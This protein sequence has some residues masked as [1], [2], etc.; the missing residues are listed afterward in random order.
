MS[1]V[2]HL[3][4]QPSDVSGVVGLMSTDAAA[5]DP[6]LDVNG[7]RFAGIT[8][9][10][11]PFTA[12]HRAPVGDLWLGFRYVPPNA[13]GHSISQSTAGFLEFFDAAGALLAKVR[14]LDSD[15]RYHAEAHGDVIVQGASSYVAPTGQPHWIDV[16]LAV[17]AEITIEFY[18]DGVLQSAA[19]APNGGGKGRPVLTV[20]AN[21]GLHNSLW[22][23][24]WYYAHVAILDGVPTIGRRFVRRMPDAV[25]TYA[26]MV[27]SLDALKDDDLATRVASTAAGQ[28]L[29][30]SLTGPSGP[31]E[32]TAIA[33]VHL[34][35]TAQAGTEGPPAVAG[36]LRMAGV[37]HDATPEAVPT[38]APATV[39]ASWLV[40]PADGSPWTLL[41]LPTEVG[42][43]SA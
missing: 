34:K 20:F 14:P 26:E 1:H 28:R 22:T 39:Y 6:A 43:V 30:F 11:S 29:S 10:G 24:F 7:I 16:R 21:R 15:E 17:G 3:G 25:L 42:I 37:N 5:F 23:R 36:F 9:F 27:G 12:A 33:G 38:L 19:T 2:L 13:D 41:T 35:A 32:D 40:N 8:S 18:A 4:H 31:A